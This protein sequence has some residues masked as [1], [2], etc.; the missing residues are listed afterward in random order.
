MLF[1]VVRLTKDKEGMEIYSMLYIR[2]KEMFIYQKNQKKVSI[3]FQ[4]QATTMPLSDNNLEI[5]QI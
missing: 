2:R 5:K 3:L 1:V 4:H